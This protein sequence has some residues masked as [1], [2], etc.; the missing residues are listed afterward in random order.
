MIL[1]LFYHLSKM[2]SIIAPE[3]GTNINKY[4]SPAKK[5]SKHSYT[6]GEDET[7]ENISWDKIEAYPQLKQLDKDDLFHGLFKINEHLK[8][9]Q[10]A[11]DED[12]WDSFSN[13]QDF[14][15]PV[16][17]YRGHNL[18]DLFEKIYK[19]IGY[20]NRKYYSESN[21]ISVSYN[22]EY[23]LFFVIMNVNCD[24]NIVTAVAIDDN[25]NYSFTFPRN[26]SG[27]WI[28]DGLGGDTIIF[29]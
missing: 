29:V 4:S 23:D 17:I 16:S 27:D 13:D 7:T 18:K 15:F 14:K 2:N 12:W 1:K 3:V 9:E 25:G 22:G 5:L 19:S 20:W 10:Y 28:C 24:V 26:L 11:G 6:N 8:D 21:P